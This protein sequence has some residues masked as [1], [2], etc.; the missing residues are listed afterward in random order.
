MRLLR[1]IS[2]LSRDYYTLLHII[3]HDYKSLRYYYAV[4]QGY[5]AILRIIM[6]LLCVNT[7]YYALLEEYYK[8]FS[9]YCAIVT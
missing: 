5:N 8:L 4:I 1:I 7:H 3:T 2:R 6:L 9:Y